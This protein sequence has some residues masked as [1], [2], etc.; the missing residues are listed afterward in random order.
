MQRLQL[1][2]GIQVDELTKGK[3]KDLGVKE[4]FIITEINKKPVSSVDDVKRAINQTEEGRP[5][6]IEGVYPNGQWAY[7][8]FRVE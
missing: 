8:V 1:N 6:L 7:Y 4:G 2:S 3:L 5:I